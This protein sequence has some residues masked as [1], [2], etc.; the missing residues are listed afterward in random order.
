MLRPND[1]KIISI[2][3]KGM[4]TPAELAKALGKGY[5]EMKAQSIVLTLARKGLVDKTK[6]R[7][8]LRGSQME[9][10]LD[11]PISSANLRGEIPQPVRRQEGDI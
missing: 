7:I 10:F 11:R 5:T 6:A 2:L 4:A 9:K 3:E 1:N 8:I